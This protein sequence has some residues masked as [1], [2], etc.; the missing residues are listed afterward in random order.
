MGKRAALLAVI[1]VLLISCKDEGKVSEPARVLQKWVKAIE[2]LDYK[3]YCKYEAYPKPEDVF[4]EMYKDYYLVDL[5]VT[6]AEDADKE[7]ARKDYNGDTFLHRTVTFEASAV[8]RNNG[9]PYQLHRGNTV[10]IKF[11]DGKR[12]NDGWL[13]SNRT[14][15]RINK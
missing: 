9:K 4:R 8:N 11:L 6:D 7:K 15:T 13:L 14:I 1:F 10:F 3:S 2:K 5:M 12:E